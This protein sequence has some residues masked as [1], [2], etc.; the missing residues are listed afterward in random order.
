M[1]ELADLQGRFGLALD[2]LGGEISALEMFVGDLGRVRHRLGIYRGNATASAHKAL[3]AAYPVIAK[4]VGTEFFS[5]LA[6][7]YRSRFPSSDGDLNEYGEY[8]A[9]FLADFAPARDLPYLPDVARLEWQVHRAHYAADV[10]PLD[11]ARLACIQPENQLQLCPQLHPACA[12]LH[13]TYP[14]ARLWQ[15]HQ[16]TFIGE[17]EVDF[18]RGSGYVLVLRRRFKVE[19]ALISDAEAAFLATARAGATL[20]TALSAAQSRDALFDLGRSLAMWVE[21]SVIVDLSLDGK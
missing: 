8:F 1:C 2:A 19:V 5:G 12:V 21:S 17:F 20:V 6:G 3:E 14:L 11:P 4:I 9:G 16:D 10:A 18:S 15:V 7:Q 13:S